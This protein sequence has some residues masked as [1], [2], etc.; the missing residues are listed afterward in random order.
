MKL[1]RP[2]SPPAA[3]SGRHRPPAA[4]TPPNLWFL[5]AGRVELWWRRLLGHLT[6]RSVYLQN[7][8]R[9]AVGLAVARVVAGS[10]DLS[11]GFWVL[12]ATLSLMRTSAVA[13]RAALLRAFAGTVAG[14]IV[15]GTVLT[16]VGSHT[17]VYIWAL[18]PIM[19]VAF[20]AGP[21][22]GVA[23][24]QA[25][26]TV[27]VALLFAQLAPADWHLAEVRLVDVLVGGLIG[28][29]I[30]A[31]VW[32]RGGGGEIRRVA[33]AGLRAGAADVEATIGQLVGDSAAS[34]TDDVHRL[35]MMFD[36]TYAQ[37]RT[38]PAPRGPDHDWLAV[39]GVVHRLDGYGTLLRERHPPA[40][41]LPWP[42]VAAALQAAA[43]DV[44]NAYRDAA[45]A[46][47]SGRR[48]PTD[49]GNRCRARFRMGEGMQALRNAPTV[50]GRVL[51][52]WGWLNGL[53]DDLELLEHAFPAPAAGTRPAGRGRNN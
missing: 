47:A 20:A 23:A 16:L 41:P 43:A 25:G 45:D 13:G 35:A 11:H 15:A 10:L 38:E 42:D 52:G 26:F 19:V 5:H 22:L 12:L 40:A 48:L 37:F 44:A 53:A 2:S 17:W 14:A 46:I 6:P 27:V 51:D 21:L 18:P 31:A 33:A 4:E 7:A 1:A 50:A 30:G 29:A 3:S 24:A 28:A 34:P 8:V 32:P 49:A 9:L 39:L 36:H